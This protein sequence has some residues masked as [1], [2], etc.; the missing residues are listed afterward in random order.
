MLNTN[1]T[2]KRK[3]TNEKEIIDFFTMLEDK[4]ENNTQK[5]QNFIE[6]LRKYGNSK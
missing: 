2:G 5:L 1:Y 3:A 4:F 6:I